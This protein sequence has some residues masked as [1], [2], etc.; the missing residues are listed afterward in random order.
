[1]SRIDAAAKRE[2][3]AAFNDGTSAARVTVKT[4]SP[5]SAW[6]A[7]LGTAPQP[8]GADGSLTLDVPATGTT[9][10][11]ANA[12][13]PSA[14][15]PR[16]TLRAARDDLSSLLR[17]TAAVPGTAPVSVAFGVRRAN[18]SWKRLAIDDSPPYRAFV[19]PG[20]YRKNEQVSFI[21]VVRSLDGRTAVSKVVKG[22]PR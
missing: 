9:L 2:C 22:E 1:V 7:L 6:T 19:T 4:S 8:S 11:R 5:S 15:P 10:L 13:L 12:E 16:P 3:V 21:A 20:S 18:G 14:A 17:L